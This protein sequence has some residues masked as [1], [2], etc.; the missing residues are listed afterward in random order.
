MFES[1][2]DAFREAVANFKDEMARDQVPETVDRLLAGMVEELTAAKTA[3]R[4]LEDQ[5]QRTRA[6]ADKA[7]TEIE[8][9]RRRERMAQQIGDEETAR[10]A[11]EFGEKYEKRRTL[12]EHKATALVEEL[13]FRRSELDD[14]L[15]KI[16]EARAKR[17][18]LTATAGRTG[19]RESIQAADDLFGELDRMAS[20]IQ[21]EDARAHAAES[22]GDLDL[23]MDDDFEAPAPEAIDFD[24]RLEELK[25]RMQEG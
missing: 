5:I 18:S 24:A 12:M 22:F 8:T 20:K 25:R 19:A 13:E 23:D 9:C 1:L 6:E 11:R 17:D 14:M 16:K 7:G 10:V 21:D 2:R 3:L 4:E 15:A